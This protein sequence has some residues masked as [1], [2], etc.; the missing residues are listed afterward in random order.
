VFKSIDI[1]AL[2]TGDYRQLARAITLVENDMPEGL[3]L[4]KQLPFDR[5]V[6]VIGL[7]GPPGAG[8]S[9]LVN[10]L[11]TFLVQQNKKTGIIAVDPTSPF[12][13]GSLLGDRIRM[14]EH[15]NHPNVYI[16]SLAT[17]GSLG[18][19]SAKIFEVTDVM[20]HADFDVIVIETVGVGQSEVEIAGIADSTAVVLV[21]EAGDEVQ[22]LKSGLM[23]IADIFVIN[24]SD[25]E[26]AD[27]FVKNLSALVHGRGAADWQIPVLKTIATTRAGVPEL[28]EAFMAHNASNANS[29]RSSQ[30]MAEKAFQLIVMHK[31]KGI[32][33]EEIFNKIQ[34]EAN[35]NG[36]NLYQ[37]LQDN[38]FN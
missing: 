35:K 27:I 4:L 5:Q 38:Y 26:G 14:A 13:F 32:S 8:K 6:P 1:D 30:L 21:P 2:R 17:R 25:R 33:K 12:N 10:A 34:L 29:Q 11:I 31:M 9:S 24:K 22:T 16:R 28:W 23:E 37:F 36:F 3:A 19:L 15:F 18:G 20:K 7:T